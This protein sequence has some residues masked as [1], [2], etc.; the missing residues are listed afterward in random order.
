[1]LAFRVAHTGCP[2]PQAPESGAVGVLYRVATPQDLATFKAAPA[3][4][5]IA[6][7]SQSMMAEC[8]GVS[9][10]PPLMSLCL[11]HRAVAHPTA[12][13]RPAV[14][15][16]STITTLQGY[17][18][19]K[20]AF[21]Y[22]D[23]GRSAFPDA[24]RARRRLLWDADD[25][26]SS[27]CV[28]LRVAGRATLISLLARPQARARSRTRQT[29]SSLTPTTVGA[30]SMLVT[31]RPRPFCSSEVPPTP[32]N[33]LFFHA[34]QAWRWPLKWTGTAPAAATASAAPRASTG[35]TS[36]NVPFTC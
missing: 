10:R 34:P 24:R 15:S 13:P 35:K 8:V 1:M 9:Q 27:A 25:E 23:F 17:D 6:L 20:G 14:H 7:I 11:A 5:Y 28:T 16:K 21:V 26:A 32:A 33:G 3:D 2:P 29:T 19:Y 36:T 12:H 4:A 22:E 31:R 18:K 30:W